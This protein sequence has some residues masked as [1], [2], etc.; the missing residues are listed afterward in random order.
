MDA[1]LRGFIWRES[2]AQFWRV[3]AWYDFDDLVRDAIVLATKIER[4]YRTSP[5][6]QMALFKAAFQNHIHDLA[7]KATGQR[8]EC[9]C[10]PADLVALSPAIPP[11]SL[12]WAMA[13]FC[14]RDL[15]RR[16]ETE[17][18]MRPDPATLKSLRAYL[19]A[20]IT[21]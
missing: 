9:A 6:H 1:G 17:P 2:R 7:T 15:V 3:P 21:T 16:M 11:P 13:P 10:D 12:A 14:F 19:H 5:R 20:A 18:T 8:N 4:T